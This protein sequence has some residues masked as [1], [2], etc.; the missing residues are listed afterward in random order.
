MT[1]DRK[2][3]DGFIEVTTAGG[4]G[5]VRVNVAAIISFSAAGDNTILVLQGGDRVEVNE[6]IANVDRAIQEAV[7]PGVGR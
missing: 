3:A 2:V 4:S 7:E 5:K 1:R 6:P